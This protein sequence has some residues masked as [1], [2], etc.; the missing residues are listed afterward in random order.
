MAKRL[1]LT[2]H[3]V[4]VY[5][6]DSKRVADFRAF[7]AAHPI[8]AAD[9]D[10]HARNTDESLAGS[11]LHS[12]VVVIC[13]LDEPQCE[14]VLEALLP[15]IADVS[16]AEYIP[17]DVAELPAGRV[18]SILVTSTVAPDYV[19]A[20][21]GR[22]CRLQAEKPSDVT[23]RVLDAPISGG[24]VRSEQGSLIVMVGAAPADVDRARPVLRSLTDYV[25][26]GQS[27]ASGGYYVCGPHCGDGMMVK[28]C[29]QLIAGS[30]LACAAEGYALANACGVYSDVF[31]EICTRGAASSFMLQ[32]RGGRI[33]QALTGED[34]PCMSRCLCSL[35][36]Y[37]AFATA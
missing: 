22:V 29:H 32:N 7:K 9:A 21:P 18:V 24:P 17:V 20:L 19:A 31:V 34:P 16:P 30:N 15:G 14:A 26:P 2:G 11:A 5:D 33:G 36:V 28:I 1:H 35:Y 10:I 8:P 3:V 6:V 25:S 23:Y 4:N 37:F 12:D 27:A 13:V